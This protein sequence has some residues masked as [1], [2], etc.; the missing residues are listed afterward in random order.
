MTEDQSGQAWG[1]GYVVRG[2]VIA[3][4]EPQNEQAAP[5]TY[6]HKVASG[7]HRTEADPLAPTGHQDEVAA[8]TG[9]DALNA[10]DEEDDA[11]DRSAPRPTPAPPPPAPPPPATPAPATPPPTIPAAGTAPATGTT[12]MP[13]LMTRTT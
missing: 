10:D 8:V 11:D 7:A 5:V 6:F 9:P 4:G 13:R 12:G 2:E 1:E 3:E